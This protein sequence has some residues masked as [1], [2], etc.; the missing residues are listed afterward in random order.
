MPFP[1]CGA[2]LGGRR[3][4]DCKGCK[5]LRRIEIQPLAFFESTALR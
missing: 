4:V 5:A 1:S 3:R 2:D